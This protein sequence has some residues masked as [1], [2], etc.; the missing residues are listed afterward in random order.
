MIS[1]CM[2]TLKDVAQEAGVGTTT[3]SV[4]LNAPDKAER[5]SEKTVEKVREVARKLNYYP[6]HRARV[7]RGGRT[8]MVG[9]MVPAGGKANFLSQ[10]YWG[11]LVGGVECGLRERGYNI[12]LVTSNEKELCGEVGIRYFRERRVDG[13]VA[14]HLHEAEE[15]TVLRKFDGPLVFLNSPDAAGVSSINS[16][17]VEGVRLAVDA[18]AGAG[19]RSLLWVAPKLWRDPASQRRSDTFASYC[20]ERG[21]KAAFARFGWEG[22]EDL[23]HA[24]IL[25]EA[26]R[27][28]MMS[29][30]AEPHDFTGVIC[31]NEDCAK[32]TYEAAFAHDK[33]I[34][35]DY[36][37]ISFENHV[38]QFFTPLLSTINLK[39]FE[40]GLASAKGIVDAIEAVGSAEKTSSSSSF[41]ENIAPEIVHRESVR[42][43]AGNP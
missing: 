9:V 11:E 41:V 16:D 12:T 2:A 26:S 31:F 17:D 13:L 38:A 20:L 15:F 8:Y 32:G 22:V 35:G 21:I 29:Q 4:I 42:N 24:Q 14:V 5:F 43:I 28:K 7:F 30:F 19:H 10:P 27:R 33:S 37:V 3:V 6:N 23:P 1:R 34:P 25:I 18:L 40:S 39:R 36:S